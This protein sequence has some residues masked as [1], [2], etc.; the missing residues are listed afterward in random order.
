MANCIW[1]TLL[2]V[3]SATP[4]SPPPMP[5][6]SFFLGDFYFFGKAKETEIEDEMSQSAFVFLQPETIEKLYRP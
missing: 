2:L 4:T 3:C 1:D 5:F 6:H